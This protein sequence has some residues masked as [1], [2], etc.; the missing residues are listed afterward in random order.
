MIEIAP[1]PPAPLLA[2]HSEN[3]ITGFVKTTVPVDAELITLVLQGSMAYTDV[4]GNPCTVPAGN[5]YYESAGYGRASQ[6]RNATDGMA[7]QLLHCL[8]KP[9]ATTSPPRQLQQPISGSEGHLRLVAAAGHTQDPL[10][11][12]SNAS[13]YLARFSEGDAPAHNLERG[14]RAWLYLASG[15]LFVCGMETK[16]GESALIRDDSIIAMYAAADSLLLLF[17]LPAAG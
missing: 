11:I 15:H 13:I 1:Q 12:D 8:L 17:D 14:H 16:S 9:V 6:L 3:L 7:T 10:R 2:V 5:L 4:S